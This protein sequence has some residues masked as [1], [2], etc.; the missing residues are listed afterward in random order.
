[1]TLRPEL[2]AQILRLH[3][4]DKWRVGTIARQLHVHHD[5]VSRVLAHGG[6]TPHRATPLR[7]SLVDPYR[8]FIRVKLQE[9]PTLTAARL[10]VMVCDRGYLGS[11]SHFR[12][13]VATLRPRRPVE[14][15]LRLRTLPG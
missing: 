4:V 14:A 11:Q 1:M 8:E 7:L 13:I 3:E 6:V 5:A 2:V 9:F 12:R 10:Y 15:F